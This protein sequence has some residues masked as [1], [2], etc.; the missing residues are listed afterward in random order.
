MFYRKR[1]KNW[2]SRRKQETCIILKQ[3]VKNKFSFLRAVQFCIYR[4]LNQIIVSSLQLLLQAIQHAEIE[5]IMW[6]RIILRKYHLWFERIENL[7]PCFLGFPFLEV[8]LSPQ[9]LLFNPKNENNLFA[10]HLSKYSVNTRFHAE[11]RKDAS[12]TRIN[13]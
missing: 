4:Y 10:R 7:G 9:Q 1:Q 2:I 12:R 5:M 3:S 13:I 6:C 8:F 11:A